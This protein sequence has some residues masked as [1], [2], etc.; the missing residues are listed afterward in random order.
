MNYQAVIAQFKLNSEQTKETITNFVT[1][2]IKHPNAFSYTASGEPISTGILF[3]VIGFQL[4][5]S[6][7]FSLTITSSNFTGTLKSA[8]HIPMTN[9]VEAMTKKII[10]RYQ[11]YLSIML[12]KLDLALAKSDYD[13]LASY[14][15]SEFDLVPLTNKQL[16]NYLVN[17]WE[18][19]VFYNKHNLLETRL[20]TGS[21][22][23][24][25]INQL[26]QS[27]IDF[28]DSA[29][30][31]IK[32]I[33]KSNNLLIDNHDALMST[34]QMLNKLDL[35]HC[36]LSRQDHH[37][38]LQ[39]LIEQPSLYSDFTFNDDDFEYLTKHWIIASL[40]HN[41]DKIKFKIS[42]DNKISN[43]SSLMSL[44]T[45]PQIEYIA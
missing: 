26:L 28:K 3:Y 11:A 12:I 45:H 43:L 7:Q 10:A 20:A 25:L 9:D 37:Y 21:C 38:L 4:S 44:P 8:D 1:S 24:M 6:D 18:Q 31:I 39:L 42:Q 16:V 40:N 19:Y 2:A 23:Q 15:K 27:K 33:S 41:I 22:Y 32:L 29:G 5:T 36:L 30:A 34:Q 35:S 17:H 13:A 14:N